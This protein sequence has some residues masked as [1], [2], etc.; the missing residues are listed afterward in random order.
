MTEGRAPAANDEDP[1]RSTGGVTLVP[2]Y[3]QIMLTPNLV[4]RALEGEPP[5]VD[6]VLGYAEAHP[7]PLLGRLLSRSDELIES[8]E[9]QSIIRYA[10][11]G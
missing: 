3:A 7:S 4:A 6:F 8:V 9:N 5:T 11:A 10:V 2:L 1:D